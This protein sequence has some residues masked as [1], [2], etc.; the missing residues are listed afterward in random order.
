MYSG[1]EVVLSAVAG[2][3]SQLSQAALR[4]MDGCISSL[5]D[6]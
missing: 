5:A 1:D 3:T 4:R 6:T 2:I